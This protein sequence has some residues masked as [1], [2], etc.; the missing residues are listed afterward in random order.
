MPRL[1]KFFSIA[2]ALYIPLVSSAFAA[3]RADFPLRV[4]IYQN[5]Q[6][7][8]YRGQVLTAVEGMGRAN[9]YE[10]GQPRGFDF[11][12]LCGE[13]VMTSSGYETYLARWKRKNQSLEIFVPEIGKPGSGHTCELKADIKDFAYY[14]HSGS[15]NTEPAE[16]FKQWM[17]KHQY[18]PE[19]GKEEPVNI[20]SAQ[21]I[22]IHQ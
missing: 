10:G 22:A 20:E 11:T 13:R 16:T 4:H 17:E 18:D 2:L 5:S 1:A 9:L 12:F 8:H 6:H 14:R 19:H 15:I 7:S 21:P 3:N